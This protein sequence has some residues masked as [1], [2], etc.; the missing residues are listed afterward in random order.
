MPLKLQVIIPYLQHKLN[1]DR[2]ARA[3]LNP[4]EY[5]QKSVL[6]RSASS[7]FMI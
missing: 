4:T 7:Q 2:A 3:S 6:P 1:Q 5:S